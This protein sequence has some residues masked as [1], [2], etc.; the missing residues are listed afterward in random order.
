MTRVATITEG[1]LLKTSASVDCVAEPKCYS[2]LE[3][4]VVF[5]FYPIR[6]LALKD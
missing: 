1:S 3:T 2:V 4:F 5:C 6:A